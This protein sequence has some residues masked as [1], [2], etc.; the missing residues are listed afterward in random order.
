MT[1]M[2]KRTYK[3]L[4]ASVI[5][6]ILAVFTLSPAQAQRADVE[7]SFASFTH[8]DEINAYDGFG[9]IRSGFAPHR[10]VGTGGRVRLEQQRIER[11]SRIGAFVRGQ[12]D[13]HQYFGYSFTSSSPSTVPTNVL[14][15]YAHR[16]VRFTIKGFTGN[17]SNPYDDSYTII[18]NQ[19]G[20]ISNSYIIEFEQSSNG[21]MV[22]YFIQL[23]TFPI[24]DIRTH[25]YLNIYTNSNETLHYSVWFGAPLLGRAAT[26]YSFNTSVS[27][28]NARS[29]FVTAHLPSP[30]LNMHGLGHLHQSTQ[31]T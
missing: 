5:V 27:R 20:I 12:G 10:R 7:F 26:S 17:V 6:L 18:A 22:F 25:F 15:I 31:E 2:I 28:P 1:T 3:T 13:K 8:N 14:S 21:D 23:R 29:A 16:D 30:F 9:R 4:L 24:G 11:A 19:N